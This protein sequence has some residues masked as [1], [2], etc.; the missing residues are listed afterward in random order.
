MSN[1]KTEHHSTFF[2]YM[3]LAKQELNVLLETHPELAD[4]SRRELEVIDLL[5]TDKTLSEIAE[6]LFVSY[7]SVHF[8][9][10]NIYRKLHLSSRRQLLITYKDLYE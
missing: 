8:H 1:P 7:S 4:L 2:D 5:L 9:C 10:K 3:K 6:E